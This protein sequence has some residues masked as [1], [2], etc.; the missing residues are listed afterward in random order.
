M[1]HAIIDDDLAAFL[2]RHPVRTPQA[3]Q[4]LS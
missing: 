3:A 4:L 1:Q 2:A